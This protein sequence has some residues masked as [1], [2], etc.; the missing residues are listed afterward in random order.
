[1]A[2]V[3]ARRLGPVQAKGGTVSVSGGASYVLLAILFWLI[4]YQNLPPNL[5]L[6]QTI[7]PG[8][9]TSVTAADI[10]S[11]NTTDRILKICMLAMSLYVI[12][13]RWS[14][15]KSVAKNFNIGFGLLLLLAPLSAT[16]SIEPN[17]TLLRCVSLAAIVMVCFAAS[18]A[19]W[20]RQRFQRL[21]MPPLMFILVLSLLLG[22][23]FPDQIVE[24]GDDLSLRDAWHGITLTKNQ[25][26]MTASL[27]VIICFNRWLAKEGRTAWSIAGGA[28]SFLCLVLSR[29]NTS[30]FATLLCL[31]FMVMVLRIDVIKRQFT[32]F[33][34][35]SIASTIFL[36]EL[37]IQ[38]LM[39]GAYTLLAPIRGLTG[40]DAT[41]SARTIIWDIVKEHI[42]LA[43]YLGSG[44]GA[45]W[46]GPVRSSPSYVFTYKMYFYPTEAHNGYLD[47]VNDLG[48]LGL[49][50]LLVFLISY[51]RQALM[52]MRS[53]RNQA[54]LYL[55]VLFQMMVMNMS[56]SEWMARDST[57]TVL[58][59]AIFCM[60]RSLREARVQSQ[61]T[62]TPAASAA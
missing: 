5:G 8:A 10:T 17:E 19:G 54:A 34:S 6:N 4:F 13:G 29:S 16:W 59:L 53:D 62:P 14:L 28:I 37:A 40:K 47:I 33:V 21:A 52:L 7:A 26:G 24:K 3:T 46:I 18:L 9:V 25:F 57:F 50:C 45:Y 43:P 32:T 35:V 27:G 20:N 41:L 61:P 48:Y 51:M 15:T 39:P 42:Q 60:S 2:R 36:Y 31:M 56:E 11:G 23:M 22:V 58:I 12:G 55:A 38:G 30:L 1:M 49:V 44:Y